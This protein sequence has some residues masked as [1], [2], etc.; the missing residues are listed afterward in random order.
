[1][2]TRRALLRSAAAVAPAL[3]LRPTHRPGVQLT[4]NGDTV[5]LTNA[6]ISVTVVKASAQIP[7]LKLIGSRRGHA[8]VNLVSGTNGQGYTNGTRRVSTAL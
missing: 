8:G 6:A 4:D 5:T 2:A 3:A 1:M 7:E